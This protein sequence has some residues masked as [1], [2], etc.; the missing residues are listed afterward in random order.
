MTRTITLEIPESILVGGP[1]GHERQLTTIAWTAPFIWEAALHGLKQRRTDRFSVVKSQKGTSA[2]IEA[3][4]E[5]DTRL[6]AGEIPTTGTR[7]PKGDAE[8]RGWVAYFKSLVIPRD[9]GTQQKGLK[10]KGEP[11]DQKNLEAAQEWLV[12]RTI[13]ANLDGTDLEEAK[14]DMANAIATY[15]AGILEDLEADT[16]K[17]QPGYFIAE[18]RKAS[19]PKPIFEVKRMTL[20]KK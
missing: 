1:A 13:L 12:R 10:I 5:L 20:K 18:A 7:A 14:A 2:A 19:E 11:I 6:I 15:G 17:G 4:K 9:D 3:L 8:T 16:T